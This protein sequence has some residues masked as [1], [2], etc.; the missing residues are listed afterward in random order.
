MQCLLRFLGERMQKQ[1]STVMDGEQ[2]AGDA[3]LRYI[4]ANF[5]KP[6]AERAAQRHPDGPGELYIFDVFADDLPI[7]GSQ[8]LEPLA[9][10]LATGRQLIK[11]RRKS[12][13]GFSMYQNWYDWQ[14]ERFSKNQLLE[15]RSRLFDHADLPAAKV[16][17]LEAI[18]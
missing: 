16:L 17:P 3:I 13:H 1:H 8:G 12:F 9:D 18:P 2:D 5:P 7:L 10:R 15:R 4:A 11:R 6:I 14:V